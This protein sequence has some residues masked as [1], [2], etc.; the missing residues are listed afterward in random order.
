MSDHMIGIFP[1]PNLRAG[2]PPISLDLTSLLTQA[3]IIYIITPSVISITECVI[4]APQ[5]F[6]KFSSKPTSKVESV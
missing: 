1:A 2:D 5:H 4:L 6:R 3:K